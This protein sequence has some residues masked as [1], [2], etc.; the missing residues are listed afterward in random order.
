MSIK[1]TTLTRLGLASTIALCAIST[2]AAAD[3]NP[4][5]VSGQQGLMLADAGG[6]SI[7]VLKGKCG[8]GKCGTARVRKMMDSN[9]DGSINRSEYTEWAVRMAN[10]EFDKISEGSNVTTPDDVF[11]NFLEWEAISEQTG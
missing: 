5:A 10:S 8:D 9:G 7:S 4:F 2:Q 11:Q 6:K 3:S 1:K